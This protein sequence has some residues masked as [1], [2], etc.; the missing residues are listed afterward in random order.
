[1]T[2]SMIINDESLTLWLINITRKFNTIFNFYVRTVRQSL[3]YTLQLLHYL[4]L[5]A[6]NSNITCEW[7]I[8]EIH[9]NNQNRFNDLILV[10]YVNRLSCFSIVIYNW[11][12]QITFAISFCLSSHETK[13]NGDG[14]G[15][16][17]P[18]PPLFTCP[19][20]FE[21]QIPFGK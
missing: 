1:M 13:R 10:F 3:L 16:G 20:I 19:G 21:L 2:W 12:I 11:N 14:S 6:L 8:H 5:L 7:T 4:L 17:S 15:S 18:V 9:S